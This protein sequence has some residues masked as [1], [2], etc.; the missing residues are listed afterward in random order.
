[1]GSKRAQSPV[2]AS[3]K[4]C[5]P[6][7]ADTPAPVNTTRCRAWSTAC[8]AA[9]G[10]S[11]IRFSPNQL[12]GNTGNRHPEPV[13]DNNPKLLYMQL[14]P[15][16]PLPCKM[17]LFAPSSASGTCF[18]TL[19]MFFFLFCRLLRSLPLLLL[20]VL[21]GC[22]GVKTV[23]V[24]TTDYTSQRRGDILT[25]GKLSPSSHAAL[26]VLGLDADVC[27]KQIRLCHEPLVNSSGLDAEQRTATLAELWLQQ[28]L[29]AGAATDGTRQVLDRKSVV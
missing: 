21:S 11:V 13:A 29:D 1:M 27:R 14:W 23:S 6:L 20:L 15:F 28:A 7:S 19:F 12:S 9:A 4:V 5:T 18:S 24:S 17:A 26:Q 8:L 3:R 2:R 25:T 22:A 16:G 10:I